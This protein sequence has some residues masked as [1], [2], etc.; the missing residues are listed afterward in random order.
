[1][2]QNRAIFYSAYKRDDSFFV[3]TPF[4]AKGLPEDGELRLL[5]R[6]RSMLPPAL[7]TQPYKPPETDGSGNSR[8]ALIKAQKLLEEAGGV[9]KDG[10][11]VNKATGEPMKI[12]FLLR[13]P[14]MERV[15]G[16]MRRGLERLGIASSIRLVDDA[17]YQKRVDS[18]DFDIIS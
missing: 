16:P 17:Q 15:I 5:E 1:T 2:W 11:R 8:P 14:T 7:F 4:A 6:F 9:V 10:K 18:R 13:Q 3:N 12:E